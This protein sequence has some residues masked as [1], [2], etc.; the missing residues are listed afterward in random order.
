MAN[1][2]NPRC[3]DGNSIESD[4]CDSNCRV[5]GCGNGIATDDE[6][7]DDG[8]DV[9]G[10][11]CDNNCTETAC[12]NGVTTAGEECDDGNAVDGDECDSNCTRPQCG[13]GITAGEEQCD[14]GNDVGGD[15]CEADCTLTPTCDDGLK[16]ADETDIDCGGSACGATCVGFQ[17]TGV[18]DCGSGTGDCARGSCYD[19]VLNSGKAM[20]IA[21]EIPALPLISPLV[22]LIRAFLSGQRVRCFGDNSHGQL[23][24]GDLRQRGT[25]PADMGD[26]LPYVNTFEDR[27]VSMV[28]AREDFSCALLAGGAVQCWGRSAAFRRSAT[29]IDEFVGDMDGEVGGPESVLLPDEGTRFV[30]VAA[31]YDFVC[32][33]SDTGTVSCW[34]NNEFGQLGS[35]RDTAQI[36]F[37]DRQT[38]DFG[39]GLTPVQLV[40]G[41][42]HACVRFDD[43]GI[44]CWGKNNRGQLGLEIKRLGV[45]P[46]SLSVR[47]YPLWPLETVGRQ[48]MCRRAITSRVPP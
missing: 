44:K 24:L 14:D 46:L 40:A 18:A 37:E 35:G 6:G 29:S 13:N 17:C 38:I 1:W 39:P 30:H 27:L 8:N 34:G 25:A 15:G 3:D 10:D 22:A 48:L 42:H 21:E 23:G 5:T 41:N 19:G 11:G 20:S 47:T 12:G 28:A 2:S 33:Q 32:T 16:N 7:C 26:E 36:V 45:P 31:G 4:G 9:N 43:G